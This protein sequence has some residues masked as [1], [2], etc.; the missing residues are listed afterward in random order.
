MT[1]T[2]HRTR[3]GEHSTAISGRPIH[4]RTLADVPITSAPTNRGIDSVGAHTDRTHS[5]HQAYIPSSTA[6]TS[7][8]EHREEPVT[9]VVV[10]G[11]AGLA[12]TYGIGHLFGTAV[13]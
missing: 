5:G 13:T 11:A 9:R 2:A 8:R 3:C 10:G 12:L 1:G 4:C 6:R 7:G